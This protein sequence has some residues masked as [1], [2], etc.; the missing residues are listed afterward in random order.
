[1][2]KAIEIDGLH[3]EGEWWNCLGWLT[4]MPQPG[5]ELLKWGRRG[6]GIYPVILR[7]VE[8]RPAGD[9]SDMF[10]GVVRMIGYWDEK[11]DSW[12]RLL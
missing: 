1:M 7:F 8:I 5:D 2:D 4:P 9:P 11:K 3:W 12:R 6:E 10:Y